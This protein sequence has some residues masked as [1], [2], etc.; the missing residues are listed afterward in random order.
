M[1]NDTNI[2]WTRTTF[3]ALWLGVSVW[4]AAKFGWQLDAEDPVSILI[5]GFTGGIVWRVSEAL[6]KI[7]YLGYI[8]FGINKAPAYADSPPDNPPVEMDA[9]R[10]G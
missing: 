8:V 7:P 2:A 4:A 9:P 3:T 1:Q 10:Y 6:A 5:V